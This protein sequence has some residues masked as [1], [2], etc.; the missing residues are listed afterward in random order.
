MEYKHCGARI[1][2]TR[3]AAEEHAVES[4]D[5]PLPWELCR[6]R[7]VDRYG[8]RCKVHRELTDE[9]ERLIAERH[10]AAVAIQLQRAPAEPHVLRI[11]EATR[12]VAEVFRLPRAR[13]AEI[14]E[15]ITPEPPR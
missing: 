5:E 6:G 10:A 13:V 3:P 9:D 12:A 11:R 4:W 15:R 8:G 14:V 2:P 7:G 1:I